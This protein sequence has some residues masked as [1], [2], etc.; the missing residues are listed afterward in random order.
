MA[1]L[2]G[3]NAPIIDIAINELN[4]QIISLSI[5]KVVKIW[6]IRRQNC[7]Q[8][9]IDSFQHRPE[10]VLSCIHFTPTN[11]GKLLMASYTIFPYQLQQKQVSFKLP[12]S[13]DFPLRAAIYNSQFKQIVSGC[14][15]GVINVWVSAPN[16][17][18][19]RIQ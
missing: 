14:D 3:H 5:D 10:N 2:K 8:T 18:T 16:P 12:K 7:V 13:H 1:A 9:L 11:G 19:C 17:L 4:G 15:G 6:D